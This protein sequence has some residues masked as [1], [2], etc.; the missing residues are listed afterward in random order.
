MNYYNQDTTRDTAIEYCFT[1][2]ELMGGTR[3]YLR[4]SSLAEGPNSIRKLDVKRS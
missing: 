2:L 3:F 1:E 4:N